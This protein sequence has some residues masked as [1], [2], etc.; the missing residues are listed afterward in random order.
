M[1]HFLEGTEFEVQ[2]CY[3]ICVFAC[4]IPWA[5]P[6]VRERAFKSLLLSS[7][8]R[9]LTFVSAVQF[10]F[11]GLDLNFFE[12][13][14]KQWSLFAKST[15]FIRSRQQMQGPWLLFLICALTREMQNSEVYVG[16]VCS[17]LPARLCD[18]TPPTQWEGA[19][20]SCHMLH[21][22]SPQRPAKL[23]QEN[24]LKVLPL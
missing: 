18:L 4:F 24:V 15:A 8:V 5:P 6:A 23:K 13:K 16:R 19:C 9:L 17:R 2:V 7:F 22:Q 10:E 20:R 12:H 21:L 3:V 14:R 1:W 11:R